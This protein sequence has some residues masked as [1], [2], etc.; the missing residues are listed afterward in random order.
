[1]SNC[2]VSADILLPDFNKVSGEKWAVVACDQFT[3]QPEYWEKA[4]EIVGDEP[5]ALNLILPEAYLNKQDILMPKISVYM[6]EYCKNILELHANTYI[7]IERCQSDGKI[8]HGL[9]GAV[10]LECY[11]WRAGSITPVRATEGTV[12]ERIPPRVVIRRQ[13]S[14]E[15]PH[16]MLLIDDVEK[17]VIESL[18]DKKDNLT[19]AY[20]FDLMLG[21]GHISG[22][23]VEGDNAN[24]ISETLT[25]LFNKNNCNM[26]IAVGDGNHSLATA[27]TVYEQLK[28]E[29]GEAALT[30]PARYALAEL[31]NIHDE[32]LEFEPI[33]RIVSGTDV[34]KFICEFKEYCSNLNGNADAQRIEY[35][36]GDVCGEMRVSHPANQLA[37]GTVQTFLDT[38][39]KC[40]P[41]CEV[42]YIHGEDNVKSLAQKEGTVGLLFSGMKK[43]ELFP[44]V[45]SDGSLP[46]K[47]FSMGH[48]EDKRY[49]V[50]ARKIVL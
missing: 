12:P 28:Q 11:D 9:V 39:V 36:Y 26:N 37:V 3:S 4:A 15:L 25:D 18:S 14:V 7:Y 23:F 47:T 13:A 41:E 29:I 31:V 6:K 46:R 43:S 50:E 21:G 20:D 32:A 48:A 40:H 44:S 19:L 34:D 5:S 27:K 2:F 42:D 22:W 24:Y 45:V 33:Y 49:Y 1:M 30:H 16:I 10:D 35:V 17:K 8:R 38:Y